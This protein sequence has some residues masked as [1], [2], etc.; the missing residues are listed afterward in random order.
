M[1]GDEAIKAILEADTEAC[2]SPLCNLTHLGH[3]LDKCPIEVVEY[4]K[5][6]DETG[7]P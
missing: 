3:L 5:A 1:T 4:V 7:H 6:L 2:P